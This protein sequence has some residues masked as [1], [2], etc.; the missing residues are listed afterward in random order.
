MTYFCYC[1]FILSTF[2]FF[3]LR[4]S[5]TG[6]SANEERLFQYNFFTFSFPTPPSQ[7]CLFSPGAALP[8]ARGGS[9][10]TA[11]MRFALRVTS[12]SNSSTTGREKFQTKALV[13]SSYC[14]GATMPFLT[15]S[16]NIVMC[17]DE[18]RIVSSA[19]WGV[20]GADM[21]IHM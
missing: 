13:S 15:D 11:G 2:F 18:L 4:T 16:A 17:A 8:P 20:G 9:S 14:D 7:L 19:G 10:G 5:R 21:G 1:Y 3:I 12:S 6:C